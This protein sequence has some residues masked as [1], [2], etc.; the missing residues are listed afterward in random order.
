MDRFQ[1]GIEDMLEILIND[2]EIWDGRID[3][4]SIDPYVDAIE[5]IHHGGNNCYHLISP[6]HV[7]VEKTCLVMGTPPLLKVR[8]GFSPIPPDQNNPAARSPEPPRH[9]PAEHTGASNDY[10]YLSLE[11]EKFT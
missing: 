10:G 4:C 11:A 5:P 1:I 9:G 7:S 3:P 2:I 6:R 8:F